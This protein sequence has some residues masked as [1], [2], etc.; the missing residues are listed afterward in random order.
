MG[1]AIGAG[2]NVAIESADLVLIEDAPLDV[3]DVVKAL[4]FAKKP[5]AK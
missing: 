3:V 1:L 5:T 2:T 4:N